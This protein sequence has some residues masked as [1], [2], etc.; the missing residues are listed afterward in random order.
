MILL[1][2]GRR[3]RFLRVVC[4]GTGT[5]SCL[6]SGLCPLYQGCKRRNSSWAK[7][8][9]SKSQSCILLSLSQVERTVADRFDCSRVF[10]F[11]CHERVGES[12]ERQIDVVILP[13]GQTTQQGQDVFSFDLSRERTV[14][15][16]D[17]LCQK[18]C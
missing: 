2:V 16:C 12:R 9:L 3:R 7:L 4:L 1:D 5:K 8:H 17:E 6:G 13:F 15:A 14:F 10:F 18:T 11:L